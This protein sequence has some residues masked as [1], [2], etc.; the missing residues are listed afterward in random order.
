MILR[1]CFVA[2][3][4]D[5]NFYFSTGN[6]VYKGRSPPNVR[7]Q[8]VPNVPDDAAS[9]R[10]AWILQRLAA[11]DQLKAPAVAKQFDC[12]RKTALRDLQALK[13]EGQIEYVG[14]ARTGNY[15]LMRATEPG[16]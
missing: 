9:P 2:G 10:Q 6:I 11:G 4:T 13:D 8:D 15:R 12:S 3:L 7:E 16:S 5:S 1:E 14:A